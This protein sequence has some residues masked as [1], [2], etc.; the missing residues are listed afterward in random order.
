MTR[1]VWSKQFS[2]KNP[3]TLKISISDLSAGIYFVRMKTGN[4]IGTGKFVITG[5]Q[6]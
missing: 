4:Q 2:G 6:R 1:V 3:A 5:M